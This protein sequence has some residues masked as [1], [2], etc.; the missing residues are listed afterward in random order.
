MVTTPG[1]MP[2]IR[3]AAAIAARSCRSTRVRIPRSIPRTILLPTSFTSHRQYASSTDANQTARSTIIRLLSSIGSRKEALQY[4]SHFTSLSSQK[5][6]VIKVGGA[7]LTDHLPVLASALAFLYDLGLYPII[8]HGAGPQLNQVLEKAGIKRH[9]ED[10][11][12]VTDGKTLR[13]AR[14]MFLKENTKLIKALEAEGVKARSIFHETFTAEFLD[15]EKYGFVGKITGVD[16]EPIESC[17]EAK[18]LPILPSLAMMEDGT[19][20]NVNA[21]VAAGELARALQPAK[22]MYL[23][24]KGGLFNGET[25]KK[26]PHINLDEEYDELMFGNHEWG[27]LPSL[28]F[29]LVQYI[30]RSKFSAFVLKFFKRTANLLVV[31]LRKRHHSSKLTDCVCQ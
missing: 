1:S 9:F 23:S 18:H 8:I 17:I 28:L 16:K 30:L 2:F 5:F 7:I 10:G 25:G 12:R 13:I 29:G 31:S 4:L 15:K 27:K 19:V 24:E 26:I 11:I 3:S 22:I 6:A 20:L 14:S 21:D